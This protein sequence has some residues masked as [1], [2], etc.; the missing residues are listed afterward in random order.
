M[1]S[2]LESSASDFTR[3]SIL[4]T[5]RRAPTLMGPGWSDKAV[6]TPPRASPGSYASTVTRVVHLTPDDASDDELVRTLVDV[7]NRAF[8][9]GDVGL[10]TREIAF[11]SPDEL[12]SWIAADEIVAAFLPA[13]TKDR[14]PVGAIRTRS[15]PGLGTPE[16]WFGALT[17]VPEHGGKGIGRQLVDYVEVEAAQKGRSVMNIEAM[18]SNPRHEGLDR[19]LTWYQR[20]G[21]REIGRQDPFE[22]FPE[23]MPFAVTALDL[24]RMQKPLRSTR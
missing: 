21:Y 10:W 7:M 11:T 5:S 22:A 6:E 3:S 15:L 17:V 12:R 24:I 8:S 16:A 2:S 13:Q 20:L 18:V 1:A 9:A 14:S 23:F 19:I 4:A